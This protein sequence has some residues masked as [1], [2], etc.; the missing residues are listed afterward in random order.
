M[1]RLN[2]TGA[3]KEEDSTN[4]TKK[5]S[6]IIVISNSHTTNLNLI[7]LKNKTIEVHEAYTVKESQDKMEQVDVKE[8][9][10]VLYQ[11]ITNDVGQSEDTAL[12]CASDIVSLARETKKKAKNVIISSSPPSADKKL[13]ERVYMAN[14]RIDQLVR[15]EEHIEVCRHDN[16]GY[17]GYQRYIFLANDRK[18]LNTMLDTREILSIVS[19]G[20]AKTSKCK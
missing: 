17:S 2:E 12:K 20:Y 4:Q 11:L 15:N 10:T 7:G 14:C 8:T 9:Q 6:D 5:T 1:V 3:I 13:N 19:I 16:L 18:L